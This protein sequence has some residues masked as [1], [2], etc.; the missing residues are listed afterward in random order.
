MPTTDLPDHERLQ[1]LYLDNDHLKDTIRMLRE[2]LEKMQIRHEEELQTALRVKEDELQ[3][4]RGAIAALREEL[5]RSRLS[6]EDETRQV[7]QRLRVEIGQLQTTIRV[8]RERVTAH[9]EQQS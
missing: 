7:E 6:H 1:V 8:L 9:E 5:E 4:L 2:E 3:Q